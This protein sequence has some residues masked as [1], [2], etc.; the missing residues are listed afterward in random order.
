MATEDREPLDEVLVVAAI[1]GDFGAFNELA[2]RY[3]AAVVRAAQAV[4]GRED[5]ED[6]AQEA[7]LI[8]FKAL[9]SIEDPSRFAAWLSVITRRHAMRFGQRESAQKLRRV[10]LDELLVENIG[11]LAKPLLEENEGD[12]ALRLALENL[13]ANYSL[14]LRLRFVDEMPLKRIAAFLGISLAT[15]KWRLHTGKRLLKERIA[16]PGKEGETWKEKKRS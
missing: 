2:S 6:V 1:L 16:N 11:A 7:L 13:P 3:R 5:A 12:E 9:P 14:V 4:V 10:D 8:A 15:A